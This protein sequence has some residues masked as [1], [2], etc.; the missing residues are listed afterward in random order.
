MELFQQ[1]YFILV[2]EIFN[3]YLED[4]LE[5]D[6]IICGHTHIA[7]ISEKNNVYVINPGPISLPRKSGHEPTYLIMNIF[8][9]QFSAQL[10]KF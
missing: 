2:S 7:H 8:E 6:I 3:E 1:S 4:S 9:N 10:I 5:N